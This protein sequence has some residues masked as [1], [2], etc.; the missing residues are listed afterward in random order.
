MS[1]V[2]RKFLQSQTEPLGPRQVRV[3]ASTGAMDRSGEVVVQAGISLENFR[4]NP[5]ILYQHDPNQPV[6]RAASATFSGAGLVLDVEFAPAGVSQIADEVCGLVKSGVLVGVSVGFDPIETEPMN[7]ARPR[8]AQRYLRC[9]LMEVSF[10]SIPAN[11]QAGVI[12]KMVPLRTAFAPVRR[13]GRVRHVKSLDDIALLAWTLEN[14]GFVH[15]N[16]EIEAALEGDKSKVPAML[17][18]VMQDLGAAL[19]AL[20]GEEVA[21]A[22]A[23]A[24]AAEAGPVDLVGLER[25]DLAEVL[26]TA[27]ARGQLFRAGFVR[28]RAATAQKEGRVLS[29]ATVAK[30]KT[31]LAQYGAAVDQHREVMR[32]YNV[33]AADVAAALSDESAGVDAGQ[34]ER[35][36]IARRLRV[37]S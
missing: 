21:E 35:R 15:A 16:S 14:L 28:A 31:A 13:G 4:E 32:E 34:V 29:G 6:G 17:A 24:M 30:L 3:L 18:G 22:L 1:A 37:L 12:A 26:K 36:A 2:V 25:A 33:A 20:T 27:D 10:V 5:I 7:P 19:I 11:V 8:G 23:Q 9:D